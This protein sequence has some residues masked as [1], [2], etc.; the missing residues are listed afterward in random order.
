MRKSLL[1]L[2]PVLFLLT[3]CAALFQPKVA[4]GNSTSNG[5]LSDLL[6]EEEEITTLPPSAQILASEG[7]YSDRIQLFLGTGSSN[8]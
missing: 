1:F 5:S 4:M 7:L 2:L 6:A 8:S 3:S